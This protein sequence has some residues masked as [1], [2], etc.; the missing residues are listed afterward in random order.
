[1]PILIKFNSVDT[2]NE[3]LTARRSAIK[4][5]KQ[6]TGNIMGQRAEVDENDE[7][8]ETGL[9]VALVPSA[10]IHR[11]YFNDD[12]TLHRREMFYKMRFLKKNT[13]IAE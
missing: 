2:K 6:G 7:T 13:R 4:H 5:L 10:Q 9:H 1:M 11:V 12:L 8:N 3:L